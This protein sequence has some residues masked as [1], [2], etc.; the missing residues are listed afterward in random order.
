MPEINDGNLASFWERLRLRKV[1]EQSPVL[2]PTL[3]NRAGAGADHEES[4]VHKIF[5][6]PA[7]GA[8][9]PGAQVRGL[10]S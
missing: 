8:A 9:E 7:L 3:K 5:G 1:T 6:S 4:Q 10:Q 2:E